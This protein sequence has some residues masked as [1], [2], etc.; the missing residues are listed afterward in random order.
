MGKN[1]LWVNPD[2]TEYLWL[3]SPCPIAVRNVFTVGLGWGCA[4]WDLWTTWESFWMS[5]LPHDRITKM[6]LQY[7]DLSLQISWKLQLVQN[8]AVQTWMGTTYCAQVLSLLYWLHWLQVGFWVQFKILIVIFK[9]IQGL[10]TVS[11]QI[12]FLPLILPTH[13]VWEEWVWFMSLLVTCRDLGNILSLSLLPPS[14][15]YLSRDM[16]DF[17]AGVPS[18]GLIYFCLV[19]FG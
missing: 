3:L 1:R 2:K 6:E 14:G 15:D 16:D 17:T 8:A 5:W 7:M 12:T 10:G 13:Y 9:T 11:W 4:F 19:W 18:S